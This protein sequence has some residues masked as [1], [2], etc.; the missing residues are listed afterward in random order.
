[1]AKF[2][3][4]ASPTFAAK[5]GFPT[6]GGET[7]DVL[8]TFKHRTK[9]ALAD[10]IEWRTGKGDDE[11]FLEMVVGWSLDDEF[12]KENVVMLLENHIGVA[13]AVYRA[14]LEELTQSRLKN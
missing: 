13:L 5:V 9:K 1:M 7:V 10:F 11:I 3:L 2:S 14:Y 8:V 4:K 6:A 12:N